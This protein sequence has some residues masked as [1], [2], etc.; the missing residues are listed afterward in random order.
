MLPLRTSGSSDGRPRAEIR[1]PLP[2]AVSGATVKLCAIRLCTGVT[3]ILLSLAAHPDHSSGFV[4]ASRSVAIRNASN[5]A[6]SL[7]ALSSSFSKPKSASCESGYSK[8][9]NRFSVTSASASKQR[10]NQGQ[11]MSRNDDGACWASVGSVSHPFLSSISF[12][13]GI[14]G[15]FSKIPRD[16]FF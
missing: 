6:G 10:S 1:V 9:C 4:S 14:F 5:R 13:S 8:S 2:R 7:D 15:L 16:F 3:S 11:R 12:L